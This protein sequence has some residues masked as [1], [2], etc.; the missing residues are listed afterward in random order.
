MGKGERAKNQRKQANTAI[1]CD[2]IRL[3][4]RLRAVLAK[5][6][7]SPKRK[8]WQGLSGSRGLN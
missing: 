1:I 3:Q 2:I 4:I 6:D 5:L 7:A 8:L